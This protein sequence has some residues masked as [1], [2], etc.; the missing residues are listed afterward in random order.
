MRLHVLTCVISSRYTI[1]HVCRL[2]SFPDVGLC[3]VPHSEDAMLF[4]LFSKFTWVFLAKKGKDQ[5]IYAYHFLINCKPLHISFIAT[6]GSQSP[7]E[8]GLG[9][10]GDWGGRY[11]GRDP[12]MRTS[13]TTSCLYIIPVQFA[14]YELPEL[15][16]D[17]NN[18][19]SPVTEEYILC[20][21]TTFE[22]ECRKPSPSSGIRRVYSWL[23]IYKQAR[24]GR[25]YYV[26]IASGRRNS[27][28][29]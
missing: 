16:Y 1:K 24:P 5:S 10:G 14:A 17:Y 18:A 23:A 8:C 4:L 27:H 7:P 26:I 6:R 12:T 29:M 28:M 22:Q 11:G 20:M 3:S 15:Y 2:I 19:L 25:F 13:F 21:C 9:G